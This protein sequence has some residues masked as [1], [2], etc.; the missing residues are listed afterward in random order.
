MAGLARRL[1]PA[2]ALGGLAVV[3]VGVA[4]PAIAGLRSGAE[5]MGTPAAADTLS[6]QAVTAQ[7]AP[8]QDPTVQDPTVQ[9]P[10]PQTAPVAAAPSCD[11][12]GQEVAGDTV[13]TRWGPVQ[14]AATVAGTSICE[15]HAV[16]WP[17]G[18]GRS[19]MI[20]SYAIPQLD[21]MAT[22]SHGTQLDYVSGATYTSRGYAESLQSLLDS[23]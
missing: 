11:S 4:D 9:D 17:T 15:V 22:S 6:G 21:Q 3:I 1:A 18:D 7:A 14:V 2:A 19:Q 5:P 23:L 10:A 12:G 13:S 20:S 16:T 8:A